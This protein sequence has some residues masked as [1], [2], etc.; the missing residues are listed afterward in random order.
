MAGGKW[1]AGA[2]A[3]SH[4]QFK[5]KAHAAGMTTR[6]AATKW[7]G[8]PGLTGK[9]ARLAANLMSLNKRSK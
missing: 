5:A 3:N 4:G 1:I 2:T 8:K 6:E 9:Q 7:A